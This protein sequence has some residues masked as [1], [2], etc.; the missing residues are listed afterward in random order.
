[1]SLRT[2]RYRASLAVLLAG[3]ALLGAPP[4]AR[5]LF[6]LDFSNVTG[7]TIQF[8]A[9]NP[10]AGLTGSFSFTGSGFQITSTG[11][12]LGLPG[13][14]TGTYNLGT[15]TTVGAVQS[16]PVT[17]GA[18]ATHDFTITDASSNV[19]KGNVAWIDITTVGTAGVINTSG[20]INLTGVT[21]SGSNPDLV[22]LAGSGSGIATI[23]FQFIPGKTLT[24]L[25]TGTAINSTSYSGT[26]AS[27]AGPA[28]SNLVLLGLGGLVAGAVLLRR[29]RNVTLKSA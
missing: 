27:T 24:Q 10:G 19:F 22:A 11:A 5:A 16:A 21:Y 12:A 14:I 18:G 13:N 4:P 23:T 26:V 3:A 7:A 6:S 15:I 25:T 1:M 9:T 2:N 29:R 20:S 8:D 17:N 28:P